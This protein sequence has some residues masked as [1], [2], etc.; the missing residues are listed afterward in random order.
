M[1]TI[2][3]KNTTAQDR[4]FGGVNVRANSERGAPSR[5]TIDENPD[6]LTDIASGDIILN[7]GTTDLSPEEARSLLVNFLEANSVVYFTGTQAI[8]LHRGTTAERPVGVNGMMRYNEDLELIEAFQNGS[9]GIQGVTSSG[10]SGLS[11]WSEIVEFGDGGRDA[12]NKFLKSAY[13]NHTSL[14]ST[15]LALA[16]GEV[17]HVTISTEEDP[18]NNWFVQVI[19]NAQKGVA[20]TYGGGIQIGTD[21]EKPTAV[22]DKVHTDLTGFT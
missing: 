21:L 6:L 16:D 4:S 5:E 2:I 19:T 10:T 17:V 15:A 3:F 14:D 9:W 12:K 8:V 20:G 22:L 11:N 13:S 7:D 1:A 18:T